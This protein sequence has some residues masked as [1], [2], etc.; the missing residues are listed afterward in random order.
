[1]YAQGRWVAGGEGGLGMGGVA[2]G[3]DG[4][5]E[6]REGRVAGE[7]GLGNRARLPPPPPP[8]SSP[9]PSPDPFHCVRSLLR[10]QE[11][12]SHTVPRSVGIVQART[13]VD[14]ARLRVVETWAKGGED[15]DVEQGTHSLRALKRIC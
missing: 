10:Y 14:G 5:M 1:M 12:G 8:T 3:I 2:G 9:S 7:D 11:R 6:G 13:L 4:G 15:L